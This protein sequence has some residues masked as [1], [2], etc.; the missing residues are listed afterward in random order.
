M[1]ALAALAI[2]VLAGGVGSALYL[3]VDPA[4]L[5]A[6]WGR[7]ETPAQKAEEGEAQTP[8]HTVA[9]QAGIS[10]CRNVFA[11]LGLA[12]TAG[13]RYAMNTEWLNPEPDAHSV[14]SLV[15]LSYEGGQSRTQAAGIIFAAPNERACEGNMVR[16]VPFERS[17]EQVAASL[18]AGSTLRETLSDVPLYELGGK[19]GQALLVSAGGRCIVVS[20][21]RLKKAE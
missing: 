21:A 20:V 7:A 14:Q 8:F 19:A 18:P 12:L 4:S 16:I 3:G 6:R 17:C 5:A 9:R 2:V 1:G 15:G 13:A 11:D 10:T